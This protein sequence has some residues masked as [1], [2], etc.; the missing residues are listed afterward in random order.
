[1]LTLSFGAFAGTRLQPRL[2]DRPTMLARYQT[3]VYLTADGTKLRVNIHKQLGGRV[4]VQF[5]G[6]NGN[7]YLDQ[8][9][10]PLETEARLSLDLTALKEG[11]YWLKVSNGLEMEVRQ[12]KVTTPKPA[13]T[14]RSLTI[15]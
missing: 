11:D 14:R 7:L 5:T 12:I 13:A 8:S 1:M 15:L 2:K 9:L 3:G 6:L 4:Y 10:G